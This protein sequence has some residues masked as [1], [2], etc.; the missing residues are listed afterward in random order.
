MKENI[1]ILA[2]IY[3]YMSVPGLDFLLITV[4]K[5]NVNQNIIFSLKILLCIA[6]F[7]LFC[8]SYSMSMIPT[9]AVRPYQRL[10]SII[11][12]KCVDIKLKLK[13]IE[14]IEKLSGPVIGFY[15]YEFYLY[16]TNCVKNFILFTNLL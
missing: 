5:Q 2:F 4:S 13:V 6:C 15:C 12:K 16:V 11:T 10:N 9:A 1:K 14:L 8:L 7:V 3:Y